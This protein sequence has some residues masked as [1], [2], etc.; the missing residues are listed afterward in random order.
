MTLPIDDK[1]DVAQLEGSG[2][3]IELADRVKYDAAQSAADRGQHLSGYETLGIIETI[4]TFKMAAFICLAVTFSAATDGYQISMNGNV[5]ANAGF[6][7]RFATETDSTGARI[8]AAPIFSAWNVIQSIGQI[9]GMTTLPFFAARFGRKSAMYLYWLFLFASVFCEAFARHWQVWL[10]GKLFAGIGVGS[11]QF[12]IPTYITEVSPVRIRGMMLM[13]YNF[14]FSVGSFFAPVALQV[15]YKKN[16]ENYLTPVYTQFAQIGLMILI[17][18]VIP[19][20]PAWCVS[21]GKDEMGRKMLARINRGVKDFDVDAQYNILV[22]T[23][24]HE[25]QLAEEQKR[26]KWWNIFRG[27]N[28]FRTIVSMWALLAQQF[29]GLGLF[30][31][32][33]SYFFSS[34]GLEDPF[35]IT[36]ITNA[37]QLAVILLVVASVDRLG[38]RNICCSG[39]TICWICNV[40]VGILGVLSTTTEGKNT[41][42][43]FFCCVWIVGLQMSGSTGWGYVGETSSQRLRAHTAGFSAAC[44]CVVGVVMGVLVPYMLNANQFNWG[45]KTAWFFAGLGLPFTVLAWFIIPETARRSP[46]ELDELFERKIRPWRFHK[47]QTATEVAVDAQQHVVSTH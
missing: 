17:Y 19:E 8:I 36:V 2:D 9:I 11:M 16:P 6:V 44:T 22:Q 14:W 31:S 41:A 20:S 40:A 47:T 18:V 26:E 28:G 30:Y 46:A 32:Y 35:L 43:V 33:S 12:T 37:I 38:R 21:I 42:F 45:L 1:I 34:T 25:Q 15:M 13:L 7:S 27:V 24:A 39:L 29:L 4:M 10:V 5:I 23:V 3:A